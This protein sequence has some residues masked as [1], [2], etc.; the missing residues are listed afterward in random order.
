MRKKGEES[1]FFPFIPWPIILFL[2]K[3]AVQ[4]WD[5]FWKLLTRVS[6]GKCLI[7]DKSVNKKTAITEIVKRHDSSPTGS[8]LHLCFVF[9]LTDMFMCCL[10]VQK[11]LFH[12]FSFLL[13]ALTKRRN[14][15]INIW[16]VQRIFRTNYIFLIYIQK[17]KGGLYFQEDSNLGRDSDAYK[18]HSP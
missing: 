18:P 6:R 8:I 12:K 13:S 7:P 1:S 10:C 11:P 4:R 14:R 15:K 16:I 17:G 2:L 3:R 9:W 5:I